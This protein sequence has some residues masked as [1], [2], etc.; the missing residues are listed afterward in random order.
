MS[1]FAP[2]ATM[3]WV[4]EPGAAEAE[5]PVG[6]GKELCGR[7]DGV[8][9]MTVVRSRL[10]ALLN[11]DR[12]SRRAEVQIPRDQIVVMSELV[13][14]PIYMSDLARDRFAFTAQSGGP[15]IVGA[16]GAELVTADGRR[17]IDAAGGAVVCNIGHGRR[18]VADAVARAMQS[19]DYVLS[20]WPT[21]LRLHLADVLVEKWLP[22]GFNHVFF[23]SGGS[24]AVDTSLRLARLHQL[25]AGQPGRYKI[26]GRK[27]SYHGST[28][29]TL[30][31][32]GHTNRRTGFEPM[33]FEWPKVPWNDAAALAGA[34]EAAGPETVAAFIAEPVIGAAAGALVASADYWANVRA[35]CDQYGVLLIVDEVMTGFGR[36]GRRWGHEHDGI[37]PDIVVSGK[38]LGGGYVPISLVS[39][40][41]RVVDPITDSGR[42]VMTFTYS[43]HDSS[44]AG[45]LAVLDIIERENLIEV[46]ATQGQKLRAALEDAVGN[47]CCVTEI[48]GRGLM[49]GV[50]LVGVAAEE[51]VRAALEKNVWIYPAGCGAPTPEALLIAPPF[52]VSDEQIE[53]VVGVVAEVLG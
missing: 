20:P 48:R 19:L 12:F 1:R 39:A 10:C 45:A 3:P 23:A 37:L 8:S 42:N 41:D 50:E 53:R 21:P 46:C 4:A 52:I 26:I 32:G 6:G 22:S 51:I 47:H 28:L 14:T 35:I 18:E 33:L 24:E 2:R 34:I 36:T 17:I 38:G 29:A 44:C 25:S 49:L 27:P 16:D 5:G 43:G 30:A 31:A 13:W 40:H 7:S 9:V 11:Y 15:T